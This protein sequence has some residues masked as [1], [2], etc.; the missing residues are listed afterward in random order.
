[1]L[2]VLNLVEI[3]ETIIVTIALAVHIIRRITLF[4]GRRLD[5]KFIF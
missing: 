1:M 4:T 5:V 3:K 2:V